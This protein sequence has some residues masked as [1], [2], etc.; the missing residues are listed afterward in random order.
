MTIIVKKSLKKF[1]KLSETYKKD[2]YPYLCIRIP[3]LSEET[4]WFKYYLWL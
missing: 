1:L 2:R 4:E 3:L